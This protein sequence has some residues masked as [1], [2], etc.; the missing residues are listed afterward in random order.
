MASTVCFCRRAAPSAESSCRDSL[1]GQALITQDDDGVAIEAVEKL[2]QSL[3]DDANLSWA[4]NDITNQIAEVLT[5]RKTFQRGDHRST[6]TVR[7][8]AWLLPRDGL[9]P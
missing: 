7:P 2:S 6:E 9:V 5:P 3:F 4:F 8:F 1:R